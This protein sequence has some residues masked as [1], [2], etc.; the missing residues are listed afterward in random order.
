MCILIWFP[1]VLYEQMLLGVFFVWFKFINDFLGLFSENAWF[2]KVFLAV[3]VGF[4]K[5]VKIARIQ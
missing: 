5:I 3:K 2:F 4:K 1:Y